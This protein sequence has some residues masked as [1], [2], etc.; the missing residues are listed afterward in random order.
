MKSQAEITSMTQHAVDR[1]M[2]RSG[3]KK[4]IRAIYKLFSL[5][6]AAVPMG[7]NRYYTRGWII[8]VVNG[9][10]KTAYRPRTREEMDAIFRAAE[11][12]VAA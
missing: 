3:S 7:R 5:S 9:V 10:V 8:V 2:E 6:E 11:K 1:F 4:P 12:G